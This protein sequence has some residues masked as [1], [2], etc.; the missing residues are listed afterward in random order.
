[1]TDLNRKDVAP[2][3]SEIRADS[4]REFR[5]LLKALVGFAVI[6]A[7]IVIRIVFFE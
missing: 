6:A 2:T 5:L 3:R 4:R 1:M 7:I